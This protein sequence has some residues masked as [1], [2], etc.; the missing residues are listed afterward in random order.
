MD[1]K[2][3]VLPSGLGAEEELYYRRDEKVSVGEDGSLRFG[4]DGSAGFDTYFNGFSTGKW[5]KYTV[6][7]KVQLELEFQGTFSVDL[8]YQYLKDGEASEE[9]LESR[10]ITAHEK[11]KARFDFGEN[12]QEG[13]FAFRCQALAEDSVLF[14]GRYLSE[15]LMPSDLKVNLMVDICTFKREEY[16]CRNLGLLK[17]QILEN[18]ESPLYRHM[19][20][21]ISD[22]AKTL[23]TSMGDGDFVKISPNKNAG[24]VGGFTRGIIEAMSRAKERDISHV[25]LMDDDA[26]IEPASL[27][28]NYTFL[29][30]LK[31]EYKDYTLAGSILQLN[32]PYLQYEAGAQWNEGAIEALKHKVDL[33]D[34]KVL[35]LNEDESEKV[36]YAGWW[37]CCIPLSV[38]D[39]D[40]LPLPLFIHRDDVEYGLRTGKGFIYLNGVGVWHEAFENK[41]SGTMEYYDIRNHCIVNAIHCPDYSMRKMKGMLLKWASSNIAKYRYQYVDMNIRGLED[42]LKGADWFMQ[43]DPVALH[44]EICKLNYKAKPKEEYIGYKGITEEDYDWEKLITPDE[45]DFIPVWKKLIHL[46]FIN[47]YILPSKKDKVPVVPPYNNIYKMFRLSEA[48]MTDAA[49]NSVSTKRSWKKMFQCYKNL[50]RAIRRIKKEYEPARQSFQDRYR[51]MTNLDFWRKYLDL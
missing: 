48:I 14:G 7:E 15:N 11:V 31:E 50:F 12:R 51:E 9:I 45:S 47:G 22:N 49:G 44:S 43:Q 29:T 32:K 39:R 13:I 18:P 10:E 17:K 35:L 41:V 34:V 20:V 26:M 1:L 46:I 16:V 30:V 37:Y 21:H 24:G 27:E 8:V 36:E 38:I 33:R 5:A 42:F 4:L 2:R 19:Y 25:L 6:V 23:D 3:I 40:N 28:T